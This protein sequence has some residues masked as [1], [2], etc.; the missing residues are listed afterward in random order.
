MGGPGRPPRAPPRRR[1]QRR[2]RAAPRRLRA[3]AG[4]GWL[5]VARPRAP[6]GPLTLA[7][8]GLER[9]PLAAGERVR[10]EG[11]ALR[12]RRPAARSPSRPA[13]RRRP[14]AAAA[15]LRAGWRAALDRRARGRSAAPARELAPGLAALR[16][17]DGAA[18]AA[19]LAGR[20]PGLT[21]AGDDVLAGYAAW[22]H[23][24]GAA[25]RL[26]RR[27]LL[28]ARPR[29]PAL[30]RA[31]RA[32]RRRRARRARDPRGRRRRRAGAARARC[33][34]WGASSGAAILWGVAAAAS[35]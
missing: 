27:A 18:A 8:A 24:A 29:L 30:R 35:P 12:D 11:G 31:R 13:R 16:R 32:A 17:G 19:L 6:R 9:A 33:A 23:A 10:I 22:R 26:P 2:D 5:L 34:G 21:P 25:V 15:P 1:G 14:P 28:A 3:P 7:V 20:G 4:D